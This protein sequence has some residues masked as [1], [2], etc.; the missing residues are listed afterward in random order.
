VP[1][2][3]IVDRLFG[4]QDDPTVAPDALSLTETRQAPDPSFA[5]TGLDKPPVAT[6]ETLRKAAGSDGF[7]PGPAVPVPQP[8]TAV[9]D[10]G[11]TAASGF[12]PVVDQGVGLD[13]TVPHVLPER[14]VPPAITAGERVGFGAG[15]PRTDA[16]GDRLVADGTGT[17]GGKLGDRVRLVRP[18]GDSGVEVSLVTTD[19]ALTRQLSTIGLGFSLEVSRV[20]GAGRPPV[21][22]AAQGRKEGQ[23][24]DLGADSGWAL[25]FDFGFFEAAGIDP[26]GVEFV[27][28][29][30]CKPGGGCSDRE[31]L[32]TTYDTQTRIVT[33]VLADNVLAAFAARTTT[34]T[35]PA[36]TTV[37]SVPTTEST[38]TTQPGS[39]TSSSDGT[40]TSTPTTSASTTATTTGSSSASAGSTTSTAATVSGAAGGG[41]SGFR[42]GIGFSV[43]IGVVAQQGGGSGDYISGL[44]SPTSANGNF[45]ASQPETL[46]GW[47][48]GLPSGHAE[49]SYPIPLPD[50]P[51]P[52]PDLTLQ[53][54]SGLV[55]GMNGGSNTQA[56]RAG[57]GWSEPTAVIT[58]EVGDCSGKICA[59]YGRHDGFAIS[60]GG[61]SSPLIR[62]TISGTGVTHPEYPAGQNV[63]MW[64]Y[65]LQTAND[66]RV[67]KVEQPGQ[68]GGANGNG[69]AWTTWWEVT[70]A[71]GTLYVFGREKVFDPTAGSGPATTWQRGATF[72]G[73]TG[74]AQSGHLWFPPADQAPSGCTNGYCPAGVTWNLDQVIDT[75][76]NMAI[77]YYGTEVNYYKPSGMSALWYDREVYLRNVHYGLRYDVT[78]PVE[79]GAPP[80]RVKV[81]YQNRTSGQSGEPIYPDTPNF[82]CTAAGTETTCKTVPSFY[83]TRR[84][85][86]YSLAISG[87]FKQAWYLYHSWPA[88]ADGSDRK[89]WLDE[90][91][92]YHT[93]SGGGEVQSLPQTTFTKTWLANRVVPLSAKSNLIPRVGTMTG[94]GGGTVTFTYGQT[95]PLP[96][97]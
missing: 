63:K 43:G 55:D 70:T 88:A 85:W 51:G 22:S 21:W 59:S 44:T 60:F 35:P 39:T 77:Y 41:G 1:D 32:A 79:D 23:P 15:K 49:L 64:E 83:S 62:T 10:G 61:V 72:P 66:W 93:V 38:T 14:P 67:R 68:Y 76:G 16:K 13:E 95:H 27:I 91:R 80:F 17:P 47:Q 89:L 86:K 48:V 20:V 30:D 8:V 4:A 37:E 87:V 40:T 5:P 69:D 53:Y 81:E 36:A 82:A 58:R 90:I 56:S 31:R 42:V 97:S 11:G 94:S 7:D 26:T 52:V 33:L 25:E 19:D 71:D 54:S 74:S 65:V 24:I 6:L 28:N 73:N 34:V 29:L 2:L 45:T 18:T 92:R 78:P 46:T 57:V 12:G 3:A 84:L 9:V 75:S 50:A 96:C